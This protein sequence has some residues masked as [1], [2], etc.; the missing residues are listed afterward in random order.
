[1]LS[2]VCGRKQR[3]QPDRSHETLYIV[4]WT[5]VESAKSVLIGERHPSFKGTQKCLDYSDSRVLY[6]R[7]RSAITLRHFE[8]LTRTYNIFRIIFL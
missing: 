8:Q 6:F 7:E 4:H 5:L 1:M 2:G 3:D